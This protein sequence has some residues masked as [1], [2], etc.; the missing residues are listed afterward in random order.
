[1]E[2][3]PQIKCWDYWRTC[4]QRT[5]L[6]LATTQLCRIMVLIRQAFRIQ[7]ILARA[8]MFF[9]RR[10]SGTITFSKGRNDQ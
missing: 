9:S 1:V 3:N 8:F 10:N 6:L 2:T 4:C 7:Y 5:T